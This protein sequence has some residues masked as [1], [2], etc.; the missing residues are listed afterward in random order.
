MIVLGA[1]REWLGPAGW[2]VGPCLLGGL[3]FRLG[4]GRS[5]VLLV[6][7]DLLIFPFI[8]WARV[9]V[10]PESRSIVAC[11]ILGL[12]LGAGLLTLVARG[13]SPPTGLL[14]VTGRWTGR[15]LAGVGLLALIQAGP[16]VQLLE[17]AFGL[18]D[19]SRMG[20]GGWL[21]F[22]T[23]LFVF[24]GVGLIL[25]YTLAARWEHQ[26]PVVGERQVRHGS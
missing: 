2:V 10:S 26:Q 12:L 8:W 7:L 19:E 15:L 24:A 17:F 14:P 11:R 4:L 1:L 9:G 3:W 16:W 20:H 21:L 25:W 18:I 13:G 6:L 23:L 5:W 22:M